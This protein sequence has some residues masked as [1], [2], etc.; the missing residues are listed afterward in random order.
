MTCKKNR[1]K[2][3]DLKIYGRLSLTKYFCI[4]F[5]N[6]RKFCNN[7]SAHGQIL[8]ENSALFFTTVG[9]YELSVLCPYRYLRKHKRSYFKTILES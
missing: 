1:T 3:C 6:L 9:I 4:K 7:E 5:E 2:G 8:H